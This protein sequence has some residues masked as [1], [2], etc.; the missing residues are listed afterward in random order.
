MSHVS[1]AGVV[2]AQRV[3]PAVQRGIIM[4]AVAGAVQVMFAAQAWGKAQSV[5]PVPRV[6]QLCCWPPAVQWLVQA[7]RGTHVPPL[8]TSVVA[9]IVGPTQSVQPEGSA[10][11]STTP[12]VFEHV[13]MPAV[14]W[15]VQ[16]ETHAPPLQ[17][18]PLL[19]AT[20]GANA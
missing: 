17:T 2:A 14:H 9:H 18:R 10:L 4:H 13:F 1:T 12:P 11:H 8:Q 15:F 6:T 5:Q 7:P 20:A 3:A 19:H 16:V